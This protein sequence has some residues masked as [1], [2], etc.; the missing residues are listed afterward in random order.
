M[1]H[2]VCSIVDHRRVLERV[3]DYKEVENLLE[4]YGLEELLE[5][6]DLTEADVLYFLVKHSLVKIPEFI[7]IDLT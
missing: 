2:N 7:P 6:N 1:D 3:M 4:T 5:E